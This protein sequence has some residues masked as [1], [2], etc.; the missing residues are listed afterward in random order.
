[1]PRSRSKGLPLVIARELVEA[2]AQ[3]VQARLREQLERQ[4][5][6]NQASHRSGAGRKRME[7]LGGML[8]IESQ[9]GEGS[10]VLACVPWAPQGTT[11]TGSSA[12]PPAPLQPL[13]VPHCACCCWDDHVLFRAGVRTLI[14][15]DLPARS[16]KSP[17]ATPAS[18]PRARL[19]DRRHSRGGSRA[20]LPR[21]QCLQLGEAALFHNS[22]SPRQLK[23]PCMVRGA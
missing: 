22:L 17:N 23:V 20:A 1:M 18:G 7:L 10:V 21:P 19:P 5:Q 9:R 11:C 14:E 4:R 8:G 3:H 13:P 12:F 2:D 6:V 15:H 16:P